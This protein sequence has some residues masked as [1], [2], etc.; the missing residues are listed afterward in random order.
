MMGGRSFA[1]LSMVMIGA[2]SNA[3]DIGPVSASK[4]T[5][6]ATTLPVATASLDE[7]GTAPPAA[8]EL[9]PLL[10]VPGTVVSSPQSTPACT[11]G[12]PTDYNPSHAYLPDRNPDCRR[13]GNCGGRM[14]EGFAGVWVGG[15][16]FIG[17]TEDMGDV[18]RNETY[19][20]RLV[21]GSWFD[22]CKTMGVD[23][24]FLNTHDTYH[25][26]TPQGVYR[27]A[28]V[29]LNT[30]DIN[31]R[32]RLFTY[33]RLRIDGLAGY[34]YLSLEEKLWENTTEW[35]SQNEVNSGQIGFVAGYQFGPYTTDLL[36]KLAVGNNRQKQFLN[37][38]FT[39]E[40]KVSLIPEFGLTFGYDFGGSIRSTIGYNFLYMS[41]M[42]RP[43]DFGPDNFF[44][45]AFS[46]GLEARY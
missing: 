4:Y 22:A 9:P 42:A 14:G 30:A 25:D 16:A 26:I 39:E 15:G 35:R 44:L 5:P 19:G 38:V 18:Q 34:R 13:N 29:I 23:L 3:Q 17:C 10:A 45:H 41:N 6:V 27:N 21:G 31:W 32:H 7:K 43:K 1:I 33:D 37:G 36:T 40:S 2:M 28:P 24:S 11:T 8:S 46:I 12:C 20:F